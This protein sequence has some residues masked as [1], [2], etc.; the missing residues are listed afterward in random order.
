MAI[1][2]LRDSGGGRD[3]GLAAY[4]TDAGVLLRMA[5]P[6]A[7]TY[8]LF[9]VNAVVDSLMAG[10]LDVVSLAAVSAGVAFWV[11]ASVVLSGFLYLLSPR[12][13]HLLGAEQEKEV[14]ETLSQGLLVGLGGGVALGALIWFASEPVFQAIAVDP[15]II[16]DAVAYIRWVALGFPG[17]GL[18]FGL[19]FMMEGFG[20]PKVVTWVAALSVVGNAVLNY[21]FMYGKFGLPAMGA[22]GC[23]VAS[24][25][26]LTLISLIILLLST[27]PPPFLKAWRQVLA[28]P[29]PRLSGLR[30]YLVSSTP[31]AMNMLSDYAVLM[32]IAL[33][34]AT[35]SAAAASAHQIAI[36]A[37][38]LALVIPVGI[39]MAGTILLAQ[40]KGQQD[41]KAMLRRILLGIVLIVVVSLVSALLLFFFAE[42][43]ALQ[44]TDDPE[45]VALSVELVMIAVA[46]LT[47]DAVVIGASFLLRGL[48]DMTGPFA[49]TFGIH[50]GISL[51]V[52]YLLSSTTLLTDEM[53]AK[54]WWYGLGV[55]L[56]FGIVAVVLRMRS[57]FAAAVREQ[58]E[59]ERR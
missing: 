54:G 2:S 29:F 36:N 28:K 31:V 50:W 42:K 35:I 4:R 45:V 57:K 59:S 58:A 11:P 32:V 44:Y 6:M 9:I 43:M 49:I 12:T 18:F 15:V 21:G 23:G 40:A 27:R 51:P 22:P 17:A 16:P 33:S 41:A 38:T 52:G 48:G 53:G 46:I 56:C 20:L 14:G 8:F 30:E 26:N 55:G 7:L 5:A 3:K 10:Q 19:R 25:I 24:A 37:L 39:S 34:I 1:A 13:A 47:I